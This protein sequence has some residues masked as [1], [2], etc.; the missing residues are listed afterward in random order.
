MFSL[1][2]EKD[3]IFK[4]RIEMKVLTFSVAIFFLSQY[5]QA[6]CPQ[7]VDDFSKDGPKLLLKSVAG[8]KHPG[9]TDFSSEIGSKANSGV[10]TINAG[11][12]KLWLVEA[13]LGT[14]QVVNGIFRC[15]ES[16]GSVHLISTSWVSSKGSGMGGGE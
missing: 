14:K 7:T 1:Y 13:N 11:A 8:K 2:N 15:D 10:S 4:G 5:A 12:E 16:T 9:I 6:A 3:R